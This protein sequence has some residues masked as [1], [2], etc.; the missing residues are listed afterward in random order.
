MEAVRSA[1]MAAVMV[2]AMV[3]AMVVAMAAVMVAPMTEWETVSARGT[4]HWG[5]GY[6][7]RCRSIHDPL[8]HPRY[9]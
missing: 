5:R 9:L 7:T 2:A 3:A 8:R 4:G 1:A 6:C